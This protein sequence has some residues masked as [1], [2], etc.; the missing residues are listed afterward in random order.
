MSQPTTSWIPVEV[1]D[2]IRADSSLFALCRIL[3]FIHAW[4]GKDDATD[5]SAHALAELTGLS[6]QHV[7][8]M[9]ARTGEVGPYDVATKDGGWY[10]VSNL[11]SRRTCR[12]IRQ[13]APPECFA[14]L[15]SVDAAMLWRCVQLEVGRREPGRVIVE[16]GASTLVDGMD[17]SARG[18]RHALARLS[19]TQGLMSAHQRKGLPSYRII[20]QGLLDARTA[21]EVG[22]WDAW[23]GEGKNPHDLVG[24][25][26]SRRNLTCRVRNLSGPGSEPDV[27]TPKGAK[28]RQFHLK[29]Q[30]LTSD[31]TPNVEYNP[32]D[33]PIRDPEPGLGEA[34]AA[35]D[36]P[37]VEHE[38]IS[39]LDRVAARV[40]SERSSTSHARTLADR[41]RRKMDEFSEFETGEDVIGLALAS[42]ELHNG[43]PMPASTIRPLGQAIASA[44]ALVDDGELS[45]L[46]DLAAWYWHPDTFKLQAVTSLAKVFGSEYDPRRVEAARETKRRASKGRLARTRSTPAKVRVDSER[47][48]DLR[49]ELGI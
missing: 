11:P 28:T 40:S 47:I 35:P 2:R 15:R 27:P 30:A 21:V 37:R 13:T 7:R 24:D 6:V 41:A 16:A 12:Y 18:A 44:Q 4:S 14:R 8:R 39:N 22:R 17:L 20:L 29:D 25:V 5:V 48:Q 31:E 3:P 9:L 19:G 23:R 1:F 45:E 38:E 46:A 33:N 26:E 32:I 49:K 10:Q 34:P 43:R 42:Y 36:S